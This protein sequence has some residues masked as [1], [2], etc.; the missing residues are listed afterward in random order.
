[1]RAKKQQAILWLSGHAVVL[2]DFP[3]AGLVAAVPQNGS[4]E[5]QIVGRLK[6][7]QQ[8]SGRDTVTIK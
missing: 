3:R 7:G 4:V 1:V 2:A 8:F 6:D 5:L